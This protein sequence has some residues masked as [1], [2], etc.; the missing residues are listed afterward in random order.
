MSDERNWNLDDI[1]HLDGFDD[2]LAG[3]DSDIGQFSE[4]YE[5][6]SPDMDE[7][8]FTG[9]VEFSEEFKSRMYRLYDF[10]LLMQAVDTTSSEAGLLI[11]RAKDFWGKYEDAERGINHWLMGKEQEGKAWLDDENAARLFASIPDLEYAFHADR[12]AEEFILSE[13]EERINTM[14][15][16]TLGSTLTQLR[17]KI[18]TMQQY[19]FKP[20][21]AKRGRTIKTQSELTQKFRSPKPEVREATYRA[22]FTEYEKNLKLYFDIYQAVVKDWGQMGE[23]CGYDSPIA[24]R[25]CENDIP[26]AAVETLLEVCADNRGIFQRWFKF[27]GK[28]LGMD[29]LRR[30]DIYAPLDT[31]EAKK[32]T[33]SEGVELVLDTFA[34]FSPR[35]AEHAKR[36]ID[37]EHIDSHPRQHKESG[38]FCETAGPDITPYVMMNFNGTQDSV[39]TLAHELGHAVHSLYAADHSISVQSAPL[40]LAETASTLCEMIV[41]DKLFEEAESDDVRKAMLAGKI[42]DA[43]G[44]IMRQAY[45]VIFEK[46]SHEAIAKG[47]TPEELSELYFSKLEEQFGDSLELDPVFKNEWAYIPHMVHTPFYC[48]AYSFGDLLSLA[49][50][51]MYKEQGEEF[52]PK[53]ERILAHGGS[54]DP[55]KILEEVGIDMCSKEFWQKSFDVIAEMQD[56]LEQ[57]S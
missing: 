48:Y 38:A 26:D 15:D 24:K 12:D 44:T 17:S 18:A 32:F 6:M 9:Y 25:N 41:F 16:L 4:L 37:E 21:G 2:L 23:L 39:M 40:P 45:F 20:E 11:S 34:Q 28:E 13:P 30:F 51:G 5:K 33:F 35:L 7:E 3:L 47:T 10:G 22:L 55:Q 54:E 49:L 14:K 43:Y 50:Y 53:I 36:V 46:K 56:R 29:K 57:Y 19:F 27:K 42:D 31:A 1:V 52:V 8:T